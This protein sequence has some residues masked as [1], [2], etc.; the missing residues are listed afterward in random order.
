MAE[1]STLGVSQ[2]VTKNICVCHIY[3]EKNRL[4][5]FDKYSDNF[6]SYIFIE[7]KEY[8]KIPSKV[9]IFILEF[10]KI[11]KEILKYI[12]KLIMTYN[13]SHIYLF[14]KMDT[15]LSIL[16]FAL[17]YGIKNVYSIN[18]DEKFVKDFLNK[19]VKK[20]ALEIHQANILYLGEQIDVVYPILIFKK[21]RLNYI[22]TGAKQFYGSDNFAF[23]EKIVRKNRDLYNLISENKSLNAKLLIENGKKEYKDIYCSINYNIKDDTTILT[24]LQN[25]TVIDGTIDN[26]TQNRFSFIEKLKD[27][28]VQ[29][30]VS[31]KDIYIVMITINNGKNLQDF[32][33]KI[34]YYNFLKEFLL[35]LNN[36]KENSEK[37][38]EWNKNLFILLYEGMSFESIKSHTSILHNNI[39]ESQK[40]NKFIPI[41]TT[42]FFPVL[43]KDLNNII[44]FIDKVDSDNLTMEDIA[45]ENYF[46][47]KFLNDKINEDEQIKHLLLNCIKNKIPVKLLNIYKGL[48][49]NTKSNILK[50][51][52]GFFYLSCEKLQR[53]IIKIDNETVL[54]S[55]VFPHDIKAIVKFIDINKSYII[56]EKFK[57]LKN[58][59]NNRQYT[60]VQPTVRIPIT[61]KKGHLV[62]SGEILDI[63][64]NSIAIKIK[65]DIDE[66]LKGSTVKAIFKLPNS[67][68]DDGFSSINLDA[69]IIIIV[70]NQDFTKVIIKV[71]EE[72]GA[73]SDILQYVYSRQKE[74]VLEL[75]KAIKV[76]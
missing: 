64:I 37:I 48:C 23:I 8:K 21:K 42:S 30:N 39:I 71:N 26:L 29:A 18:I 68:R 41:I 34:E 40:N 73:N 19:S 27:K 61:I 58:S 16:K 74:L 7:S 76:L 65:Q 35:N 57:F 17:N 9:H 60:R 69:K 20:A 10:E 28:I 2:K 55:P 66:A 53:Y 56:L 50:Y 13:Y 62:K 47:Y 22:N 70:K 59:A 46:E 1:K 63:S 51:S 5:I 43:K 3:F 12:Q 24:I 25:E 52:N 67:K 38:V 14:T 11:D 15:N 32:Y 45:K 6:L 49:V 31:R 75:K 4:D 33:S 54:Q 36:F 72:D 44:E